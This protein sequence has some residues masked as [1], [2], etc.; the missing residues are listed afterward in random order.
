LILLSELKGRMMGQQMHR[1]TQL[2][3]RLWAGTVDSHA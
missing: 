1:H 3:P 2:N